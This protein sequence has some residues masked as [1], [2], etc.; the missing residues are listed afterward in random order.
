ML[1]RKADRRNRHEEKRG[2]SDNHALS[3]EPLGKNPRRKRRDNAAKEDS[4]HNPA[5]LRVGEQAEC[6]DVRRRC[7]YDTKVY[8]IQKSAQPR[9][10]KEVSDGILDFAL[11][12]RQYSKIP[13]SIKYLLRQNNIIFQPSHA[14]D[15]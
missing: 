7:G 5:N 12:A 4:T 10:R 14:T 1:L 8:S 9:N 15:Y 6:L 3:A 2:G 11:H 13:F